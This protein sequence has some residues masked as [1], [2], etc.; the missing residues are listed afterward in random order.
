MAFSRDRDLLAREPKVFAEAATAGQ[1][2][3]R[4]AD[5]AVTG[6]TLTSTTADFELAGVETGSVVLVSGVAHE[7]L[8]R[9]D[10]Q[11]LTVSLLRG[12]REAAATPG[13]QGTGLVVVCQTFEPQTEAAGRELVRLLGLVQES[14][15]EAAVVNLE[16][17]RELETLAALRLIYRQA[18]ETV[19]D[20][21]GI[22][23]KARFYENE[24]DRA[25]Q[26][27]QVALDLDGDGVAD[28]VI[29]PGV[30]RLEWV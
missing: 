17:L 24:F 9:V 22:L 4:V 26:A 18:M 11:T 23:E 27:A 19:G 7:V 29:C 14:V 8:D 20:S 30:Q 5:G 1:E 10:A 12:R 3:L 15:S 25:W 21:T 28:R 13:L 16:E 2:K 6:T